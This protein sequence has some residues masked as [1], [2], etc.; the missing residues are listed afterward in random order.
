VFTGEAIPEIIAQL[1]IS[2]VPD[3]LFS[4]VPGASVAIPVFSTLRGA[5]H[6]LAIPVS[7]GMRLLMVFRANDG[8]G[9]ETNSV[10]ILGYASAGVTIR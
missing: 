5:V 7:A 4:P 3:N 2:T 1:Y 10:Q 8:A 9:V 6:D